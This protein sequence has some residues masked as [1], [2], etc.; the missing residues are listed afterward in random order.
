LAAA[1]KIPRVLMAR[2]SWYTAVESFKPNY[3]IDISD[4]F[5]SKLKALQCYKDEYE[6]IGELW[7]KF[8]DAQSNFYGLE[9]GCKRAEGLEIVKYIY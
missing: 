9:A 6:R 2:V 5:G 1:R 7:K 8:V 4:Q 3:F